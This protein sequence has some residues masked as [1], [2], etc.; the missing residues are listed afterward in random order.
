MIDQVASKEAIDIMGSL[1]DLDML[2]DDLVIKYCEKLKGD[3][4]QM[5]IESLTD[6]LTIIN[7]EESKDAHLKA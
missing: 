3:L 5:S 6:Y 4:D 1:R 2:K 7:S